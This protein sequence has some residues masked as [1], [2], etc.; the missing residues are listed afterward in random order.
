[1]ASCAA[2]TGFRSAS[3]RRARLRPSRGP[4]RLACCGL[5]GWVRTT[6]RSSTPRSGSAF[7]GQSSTVCCADLTDSVD[8]C[9]ARLLLSCVCLFCCCDN[10]LANDTSKTKTHV[11]AGNSSAT[12]ALRG[13]RQSRRTAVKAPTAWL[14]PSAHKAA[15]DTRHPLVH[16]QSEAF[17]LWLSTL[18]QLLAA[19]R[20]E[21]DD[22]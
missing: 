18:L 4:C 10:V 21:Q 8:W 20:S 15:L 14:A 11:R 5:R 2:T 22:S 1:M 19:E 16:R 13:G 17:G 3:W 12:E 9:G 6:G 7:R